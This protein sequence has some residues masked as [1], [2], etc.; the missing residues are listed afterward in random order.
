MNNIIE[1]K[2]T[3]KELYHIMSWACVLSLSGLIVIGT[4]ASLDKKYVVGTLEAVFLL[5]CIYTLFE[6]VRYY[7]LM[8]TN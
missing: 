4:T 1:T 2:L 7:K 8:N 3:A 5:S 6:S